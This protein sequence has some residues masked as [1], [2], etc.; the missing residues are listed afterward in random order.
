MEEQGRK[1]QAVLGTRL[2]QPPPWRVLDC[3]CGIGTQA[4][5]LALLGHHVV[6]TD[7]SPG[8]IE[9]A[10][11]EAALYGV[12]STFQVA[13]MCRLDLEVD[14]EF[15][16]VISCGNS[17]AHL[18]GTELAAALRAISSKLVPSGI[19]LVSIRDYDALAKARPRVPGLPQVH[20]TPDGRRIIFQV[21]DWEP[22]GS[23]YLMTWIFLREDEGGF[24][25]SHVTTR[26][27]AHRRSELTDAIVSV[28]FEAP[29]WRLPCDEPPFDPILTAFWP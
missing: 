20:D 27:H 26:L 16:A 21:W 6:G 29:E 14:G 12:Q 2:E 10:R 1:L 8:A 4:I 22:D 3:S 25:A 28:G 23:A 7:L 11:S 9:R 24:G 18:G 17:L 19:V 5:G 15:D 13:D